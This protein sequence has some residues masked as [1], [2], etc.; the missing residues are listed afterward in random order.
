M[1]DNSVRT[2]KDATIKR[3]IRYEG[4]CGVEMEAAASGV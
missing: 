4:L 1:V 3:E 2:L